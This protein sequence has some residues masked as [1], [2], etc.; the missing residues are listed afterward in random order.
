MR[1]GSYEHHERLFCSSSKLRTWVRTVG[2]RKE[3]EKVYQAGGPNRIIH[4]EVF[5]YEK[6]SLVY[7][8]VP[9]IYN[10]DSLLKSLELMSFL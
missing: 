9:S 3:Q 6:K 7:M 4:H 2:V 8:R 5:R 1:K 10:S